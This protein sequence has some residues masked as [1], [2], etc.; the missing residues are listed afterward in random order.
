MHKN[1][2]TRMKS[3]GM[4]ADVLGGPQNCRKRAP[5]RHVH[6]WRPTDYSQAVICCFHGEDHQGR[7]GPK[8]SSRGVPRPR[9]QQ[10]V[11][12]AVWAGCCVGHRRAARHNAQAEVRLGERWCSRIYCTD[13]HWPRGTST[14]QSPAEEDR[15]AGDVLHV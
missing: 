2:S 9:K 7:P 10:A 13:S 3:K 5:P 6:R 12:G 1:R 11:G 4:H 8:G 14:V 15:V